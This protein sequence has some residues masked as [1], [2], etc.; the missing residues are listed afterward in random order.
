[1]MSV[2][3]ASLSQKDDVLKHRHDHAPQMSSFYFS[4]T[5]MSEAR[6]PGASRWTVF[7]RLATMNAIRR[8]ADVLK[9][10]GDEVKRWS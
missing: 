8:A 2:N 7:P 6:S 1:M 4:V 5:R 3:M 9:I 10:G